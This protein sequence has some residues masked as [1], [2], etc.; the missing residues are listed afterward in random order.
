M[1][2]YIPNNLQLKTKLDYLKY[3]N[4]GL[5]VYSWKKYNIYP[6]KK[7]MNKIILLLLSDSFSI[8]KRITVIRFDLHLKNT[9]I[10]MNQ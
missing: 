9:V 7:I 3:N 2:K 5:P 1:K 8:S 4:Y 10:K 6:E